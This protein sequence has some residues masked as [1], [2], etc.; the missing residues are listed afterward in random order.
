MKIFITESQ[1]QNLIHESCKK[2]YINLD[3]SLP[4]QGRAAARITP[5]EFEDKMRA[6]WN[7]YVQNNKMLRKFSLDNFVYCLCRKSSDC[8]EMSKVKHDLSK[9]HYDDE[10][11]GACGKVKQSKGW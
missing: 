10:N 2:C 5:K 4:K 9:V 1:W 6:I 7:R 11:L 8:K 3:V